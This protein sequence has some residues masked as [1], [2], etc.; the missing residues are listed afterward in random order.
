MG[1]II[2]LKHGSQK[3]HP[4]KPLPYQPKNKLS[5]NMKNIFTN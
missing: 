1:K 2:K 4:E 3:K 5:N